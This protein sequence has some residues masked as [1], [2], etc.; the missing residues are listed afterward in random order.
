M[1]LTIDEVDDI[2]AVWADFWPLSDE[3][4]EYHAQLTGGVRRPNSE[5]G[6]RRR[7]LQRPESDQRLL[8]LVRDR[9]TAVGTG[10]GRLIEGGWSRQEEVGQLNIF[11]L[12][13]DSRGSTM[14]LE[15]QRRIED[16]LR[17][18]GQRYAERGV[19]APNTRALRLWNHLGF[20]PYRETS[21]RNSSISRH[22]PRFDSAELANG[23]FSITKITDLAVDW[24]RIW[25]LLQRLD[26][27][28]Q[29]I[30]PCAAKLGCCWPNMTVS[31][32][33]SLWVD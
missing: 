10:M 32:A 8:M 4:Q 1:A 3:L 14:V 13:P 25:P 5:A 18:N 30:E 15:M 22:G 17:E 33:A 12:R 21:R 19:H 11:Y 7:V 20:E 31:P 27:E 9:G 16:C 6:S 29:E 23:G 28:L 2:E 26:Q 24:P